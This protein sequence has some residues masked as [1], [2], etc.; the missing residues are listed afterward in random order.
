MKLS[1]HAC[2]LL[3]AIDDQCD[4]NSYWLPPSGLKLSWSETLGRDVYVDGNSSAAALKALERRGLIKF[5]PL[6]NYASKITEEGRQLI[7]S[8]RENGWPVKVR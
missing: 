7:E 3:I 4:G 2:E 5:M 8:W 1:P 6:A